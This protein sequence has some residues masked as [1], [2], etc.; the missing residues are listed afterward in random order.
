MVVCAGVPE[1]EAAPALAGSVDADGLI[2]FPY[3]CLLARK[4]RE[5]LL[6]DTGAGGLGGGG[7]LE[8]ALAAAGVAPGEVTIVLL[9]HLHPDHIGGLVADGGPRFAHARHVVGANEWSFWTSDAAG[10]ASAAVDQALAPL[11]GAGVVELVAD[12]VEI[13][14]GLR[15]LPAPGHSPGHVA[16][17]V[18]GDEGLLYLADA[19][20]H[21]LHFAR[22]GW[23][24]AIDSDNRLM[25]ETRERLLSR[26]ADENRR[27][28]ASHLWRP[29]RVERDGSVFRFLPEG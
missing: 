3:G 21:P 27:L 11:S 24:T 12:D 26:A 10:P 18:G 13:A 28:A 29:G 9:T 7:D 4:E 5:V 6:V 2:A 17:E 22:L 16:L 23:G 15:L 14:P 8:G 25:R 20:I 1:E 19:V